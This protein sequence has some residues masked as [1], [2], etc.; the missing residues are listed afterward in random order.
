[1]F[2]NRLLDAA[3]R[4]VYGERMND[5]SVLIRRAERGDEPA[6]GRL[7]AALLRLHYELDRDRFLPPGSDPDSGYG[8]FLNAQRKSDD[9]VVLV[10]ERGGEV[11]GYVYAGIEPHSWK[12]LRDRAGFVHDI[13]VDT[14]ARG[15]GVATR[16]I[17]AA[18]AWL[19]ERGV[20]RVMLWTA[21]KNS[22]A[23]QLFEHLGFRRTMI[24]MTREAAPR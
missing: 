2:I 14:D 15:I 12:E 10:A 6:L 3:R 13:I 9:V 22:S 11:V 18:A 24:E 21:Q 17:E 1:M 19:V 8:S 5:E 7:G 4:P 16:L 23:Q 20:A